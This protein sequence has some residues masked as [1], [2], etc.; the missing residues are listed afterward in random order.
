MAD[1]CERQHDLIVYSLGNFI[2]A[3]SSRDNVIGAI[4]NVYF[5]KTT[6]LTAV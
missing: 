6:Q 2:N 1:R 5:D 4:L 3:Q